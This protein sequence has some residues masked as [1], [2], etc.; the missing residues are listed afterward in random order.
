VTLIAQNRKSGSVIIPKSSSRFIRATRRSQAT[1][2]K[3]RML[4]Q[5]NQD[6]YNSPGSL[7]PVPVCNARYTGH[8][9]CAD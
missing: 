9:L 3:R 2:G 7:A 6:A 4:W 8:I 5:G 1:S